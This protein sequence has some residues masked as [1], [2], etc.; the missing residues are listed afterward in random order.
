MRTLLVGL[1]LAST[2]AFAASTHVDGHV[3]RDGT[4]V[5]PHF[6]TTPDNSQMNNW[7]TQGNVN[8]YTGQQGTVNPYAVPQ[9]NFNTNPYGTPRRNP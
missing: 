6:R 7:S 1:L 9:P 8:P 4:Y 5:P 3:R 2:S